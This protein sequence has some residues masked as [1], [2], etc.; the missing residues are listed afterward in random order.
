VELGLSVYDEHLVALFPYVDG[1]HVEREDPAQ[2]EAAAQLLAQLHRAMLAVSM[3]DAA[4]VQH[5]SE[6]PWAPRTADP[7]VLYDPELDSWHAALI[8]GPGS[9]TYG[10]IHGD[11]YR[12]NLLVSHGAITAVLDWDDAHPDVLM[13]EL[14]LSAWEFA[15]TASGEDW[16]PERARA[17][18][19]AYRAAGGPCP[20]GE[21]HMLI[22]FIR[23]RMREQIRYNLAAAAA[24][25]TWDPDYVDAEIRAFQRLRGQAF[26]V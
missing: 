14:A 4:P 1:H 3:R 23:W 20:A 2:R 26:A 11:Y 16:H 19:E 15:K 6:A 7:A 24:G 9:F 25:E 22:P 13:Q 8:Q 5:L 21:Y 12:R 17:F 18:V 10:P